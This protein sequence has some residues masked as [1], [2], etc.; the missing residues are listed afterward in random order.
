MTYKHFTFKT[1]KKEESG[2]V[3]GGGKEELLLISACKLSPLFCLLAGSP[4]SAR[5]GFVPGSQRKA[6]GT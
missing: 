5:R 1:N 3:W 4:P 6:T 2:A